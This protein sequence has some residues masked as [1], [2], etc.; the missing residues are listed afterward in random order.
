MSV[1]VLATLK[2]KPGLAETVLAGL[3][4]I[5]PETRAFSGCESIKIVHDMD[6]PDTIGLVEEWVARSDHE[7]YMAWRT[8][9]GT[10][11]SM[12]EVLAEPPIFQYCNQRTDIWWD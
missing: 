4:E 1:T 12:A 5:L 2:L 7:A 9:T 3:K 10:L 11:A 6:N 8:E